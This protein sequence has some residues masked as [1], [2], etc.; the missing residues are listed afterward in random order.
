MLDGQELCLGDVPPLTQD[1]D[2][3]LIEVNTL[4]AT[5]NIEIVDLNVRTGR[6]QAPR[7]TSDVG[8]KFT[9]EGTVYKIAHEVGFTEKPLRRWIEECCG[10]TSEQLILRL[11]KE[12]VA[13]L[14]LLNV[15][16]ITARSD[17]RTFRPLPLTA[18][19]ASAGAPPTWMKREIPDDFRQA[20]LNLRDGAT[21]G[22]ADPLQA[23][24]QDYLSAYQLMPFP[25]DSE[26][27]VVPQ[28][29]NYSAWSDEHEEVL[30]QELESMKAFLT[31][32]TNPDR[33]TSRAL[34]TSTWNTYRV[35]VE[36]FMHYKTAAFPHLP[37]TLGALAH[38]PAVQSF[39]TYNVGVK[40]NSFGYTAKL[41]YNLISC[42][43]AS[44]PWSLCPLASQSNFEALIR[45]YLNVAYQLY[46]AH[47]RGPSRVDLQLL[48]SQNKYLP[49]AITIAK[50]SNYSQELLAKLAL[51][52]AAATPH[53]FEL[54]KEVQNL[55]LLDLTF[56]K[57]MSPRM[58][59]LASLRSKHGYPCDHPDCH[60]R[61]C[62]GNFLS[63]DPRGHHGCA[64]PHYTM[65][66][67]HHKSSNAKR[68]SSGGE[69]TLYILEGSTL[70][71]LMSEWLAWGRLTIISR[72]SGGLG[73]GGGRILEQPEVVDDEDIQE[74]W[75]SALFI[76]PASGIAYTAKQLGRLVKSLSKEK[77]GVE[78]PAK[79]GRD[80][81]AHHYMS[82][83]ITDDQLR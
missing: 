29:E 15:A 62:P 59:Q 68:A 79:M 45:Q 10:L 48:Q 23:R 37:S 4:F 42:L 6:F 71:E 54:A 11:S 66:W 17:S 73:E 1:S 25:A 32:V 9:T 19:Y 64:R 20:L 81:L 67:N 8:E 72:A 57:S 50:V 65:V 3:P 80:Q 76:N 69:L 77:F 41:L 2:P 75:V 58:G 70:Y 74:Q 53:N 39:I 38:G 31:S 83:G 7:L 56:G 34:Q 51:E 49:R 18:L 52:D 27:C 33:G 46:S 13:K 35:S 21:V 14:R 16:P 30:Q 28:L 12:I 44:I 60:H 63:N 22:Q 5:S 82:K 55:I 40:N 47:M 24:L 26:A 43:K 78:M 61:G 36:L